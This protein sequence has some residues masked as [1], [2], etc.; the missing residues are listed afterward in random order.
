MGDGTTGELAGITIVFCTRNGKRNSEVFY[1]D[2][3]F[4][5]LSEIH[6]RTVAIQ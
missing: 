1:P 6:F 4:N 3:I 5:D 2:H